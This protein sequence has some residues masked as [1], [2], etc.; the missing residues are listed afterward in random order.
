MPALPPL[1]MAHPRPTV[2]RELEPEQLPD[3]RWRHGRSRDL[4]MDAGRPGRGPLRRACWVG[5]PPVQAG[6]V[7]TPMGEH[8]A[9]RVSGGPGA[10]ASTGYRAPE[11]PQS[12]SRRE[13]FAARR[14]RK[15][16]RRLATFLVTLAL[17][18]AAGTT[19]VVLHEASPA[20]AALAPL[21]SFRTPPTSPLLS[22]GASTSTTVVTLPTVAPPGTS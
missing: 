22:S 16:R 13:Y 14:H 1:R 2:R 17:V 8:P 12:I 18:I 6:I 3:G 21:S 4:D 11:S 5:D 7:P 9:R 20:V 10:R 15:R 19:A